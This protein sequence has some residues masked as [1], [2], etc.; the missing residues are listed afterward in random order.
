M[1][2]NLLSAVRVLIIS[3]LFCFRTPPQAQALR[4]DIL[5]PPLNPSVSSES[6]DDALFLSEGGDEAEADYDLDLDGHASPTSMRLYLPKPRGPVQRR[7]T[8]TGASPTSQRPPIDLE[9]VRFV[10]YKSTE[11]YLSS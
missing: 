3:I 4:S 1:Y 8:I 9:K 6:D 5:E 11:E 10:R 7:A 2:V